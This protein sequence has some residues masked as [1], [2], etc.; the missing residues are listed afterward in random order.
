MYCLATIASEPHMVGKETLLEWDRC[1]GQL[2]KQV[3]AVAEMI[4][5]KYEAWVHERGKRLDERML[6]NEA[7]MQ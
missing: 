2:C 3:N 1:I 5:H 6:T 7:S 4:A